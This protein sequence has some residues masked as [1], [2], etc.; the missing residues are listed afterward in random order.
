MT[1]TTPFDDVALERAVSRLN[2]EA[3]VTSTRW[4]IIE[5]PPIAVAAEG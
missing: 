4:G 3:R 1:T 2:L 5:G